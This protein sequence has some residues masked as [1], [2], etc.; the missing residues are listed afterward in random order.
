MTTA[1]IALHVD[2]E[3]ARAYESMTEEERNKIEAVLSLRLRGLLVPT[4]I[5]LHQ[6]MDELGREAEANGLTPEILESILRGEDLA[7]AGDAMCLVTGDADL[8]VL[9]PFHGIPILAPRRFLDEFPFDKDE[10]AGT[11]GEAT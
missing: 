9:D 8:L 4:G 1:P 11:T 6:A 2:P 5:T 3:A 10:P 7:V